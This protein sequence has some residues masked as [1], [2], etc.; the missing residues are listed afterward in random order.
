MRYILTGGGTGGHIYP[1]IALAEALHQLDS[2]AD[3]LYIGSTEGMEAKIV[4]DAGIAYRGVSARKLKKL[5]APGTAGV[6]FSLIKGY[7]EASRLL[8]KFQPDVV[9]GTGGYVAAAVILAASKQRRPTVILEENAVP[10][11]TN[12]LLAKRCTKVCISFDESRKAFPAE[13]TMLTGVP[14]R[15]NIHQHKNKE[16]ARG[17][18]HLD[19]KRFTLLVTGGSQ[20]AQ[21]LNTII[22]ETASS[23]DIPIQI[24]HQLGVN[25]FQNFLRD[26]SARIDANPSVQYHPVPYL[27]NNQAPLAYC[28]ADLI[29]CRCGAST[30]AEVAACGLPALLVP[31]P[32]AYADH[33]T[34]NARAFENAGGGIL[35]P[36]NTLTS[37]KLRFIINEL[38]LNPSKC[39]SMAEASLASGKPEA[40]IQIA[41]L[42]LKLCEEKCHPASL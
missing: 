10:G 34:A 8:R 7:V 16:K 27:D 18:L 39:L 21:K 11:R 19:P 22:A 35:L 12:L 26:N 41:S 24:L 1:A 15:E 31:L 14:I 20:G 23:I 32:T 13:K 4:P 28:A 42:A 36:Q 29:L 3:I 5:I 2:A 33:Q 38:Y 17:E 37:E 9:I 40:G 25:N 6:V 30:L